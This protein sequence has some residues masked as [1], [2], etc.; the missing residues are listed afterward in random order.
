ME[1][2][3]IDKGDFYAIVSSVSKENLIAGMFWQLDPVSDD[4]LS[5]YKFLGDHVLL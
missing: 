4:F 5:W 1:V 2:L 3:L